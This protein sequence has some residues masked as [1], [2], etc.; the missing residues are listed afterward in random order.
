MQGIVMVLEVVEGRVGPQTPVNLNR[1]HDT[2][3][4]CTYYRFIIAPTTRLE[5]WP[6]CVCSNFLCQLSIDL[7]DRDHGQQK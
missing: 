4:Q 2:Q 3:K 6:T 1:S 7:E 5:A